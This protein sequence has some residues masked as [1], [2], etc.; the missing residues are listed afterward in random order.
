MMRLYHGSIEKVLK[1]EIRMS[2]R[3]LDY[4]IGFYTTTSEQQAEQWVLRKL[5]KQ[6]HMGFVN[7]YGFDTNALDILNTKH[8]T[9]PDG[10]WLD[11]V[12][13]NRMDKDFHHDYDIVYGPVANDRV[14]AAF[15]L[16]ESGLF[17]K[18]Q[19][20]LELRTYSLIDQLLFHTEKSLK[21]L[22]YIETKEI[23]K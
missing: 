17:N 21:Y 18:E 6:K 11:F 19:L 20:I 1:P 22:T 9:A 5:G 16:Y 8:F 7:V 10:E 23:F 4:G 3:T 15:S 14:Y 2:T 13:S 12:M